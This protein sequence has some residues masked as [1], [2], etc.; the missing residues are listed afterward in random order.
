MAPYKQLFELL[1][2]GYITND[3]LHTVI[4]LVR[5]FYNEFR[6]QHT[7]F[8]E[9][10]VKCF[11][12]LTAATIICHNY[13][14]KIDVTNVYYCNSNNIQKHRRPSAGMTRLHGLFWSKLV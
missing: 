4:Q 13:P 6:I 12:K 10:K 3:R 9:K 8:F 5:N 14:I 2:E 7:S 1:G 11:H